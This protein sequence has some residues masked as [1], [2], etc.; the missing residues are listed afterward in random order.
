MRFSA[1]MMLV[2]VVAAVGGE[3]VGD[4][5]NK[6]ARAL[7]RGQPAA[8]LALAD[9]AVDRDGR[10]PR[11]YLLRAS[12]QETLDNQAAAVADYSKALILDPKA[13]EIYNRRGSAFF[14]F[15]RFANSIEDFDRFLQLRPAEKPGHWR[16]GISLYYAGRYEDGQKQF[17]GYEVV[18]TNDVENAIWQHLC[19]ARRV[20]PKK[21]QASML[22]IGKDPRVPMK[23]IYDLFGGRALPAD[24]LAAAQ[25]GSP[26][27]QKRTQQLF[28]A[29]LYLGL[30]YDLIGE[31]RLAKE[32]LARAVDHRIGHYM[33]DVAR[34]H[35]DLL[36]KKSQGPHR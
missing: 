26:T 18:N 27:P 23:Q 31:G 33:W 12:I 22:R 6:A 5:L 21:A 1:L 15:G 11:T 9:Q 3:N 16:R 13:A 29:H 25:A 32:H 30:Y 7:A 19:L 24:V 8:A 34:V 36:T 14:K 17:E 10:D 35:R 2:L 20:G 4:L 28:Y